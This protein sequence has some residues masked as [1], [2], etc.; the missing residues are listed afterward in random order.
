MRATREFG[1]GIGIAA[2]LTGCAIEPEPTRHRASAF[3]N[4]EELECVVSDHDARHACEHAEYGPFASVTAQPYPGIVTSNINTPHMAYSVALPGSG[5]DYSGGTYYFPGA[6]GEYAFFVDPET[7]LTLYDSGG[8]LI[9]PE[10]HGPIDAEVCSSLSLAVVYELNQGQFY[11]LVFGPEDSP[12]VLTVV[13]YLGEHRECESCEV[14]LLS[15]SKTAWPLSRSD[16]RAS[17]DHPISFEIPS[18][19]PVTIGESSAGLASLKF[20][21]GGD[22]AMK[23]WY[24]GSFSSPEEFRFL[25]CDGGLQPGDSAEADDFRLR[26]DLGG[27]TGGLETAVA[28]ELEDDACHEHEEHDDEEEE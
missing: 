15:A 1:A 19:I 2:L 16:G 22:P 3:A 21:S 14:V 24:W 28:L 20:K 26:I 11:T 17:L 4:E 18:A 12:D 10:A 8:S 5:T 27:V 25:H 13:E 7:T 6:S 23:C 9:E